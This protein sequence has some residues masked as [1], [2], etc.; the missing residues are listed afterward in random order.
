M[1]W[2]DVSRAP[3]PSYGHIYDH[4]AVDFEYANGAHVLSMCRQ[5]D[6]TANHVGERFIG[7]QGTTDGNSKITGPRAY[8][9][10]NSNESERKNPYVEEHVDLLASIRAGKPLNEGHQVAESTLTAIMGREAAYTGQAIVWDDML[11][12]SLDLTPTSSGSV[13]CS[14]HRWRSRG[15]R[16]SPAPGR[17]E[18]RD[19]RPEP[20]DFTWRRGFLRRLP[21]PVQPSRHI[22]A[23]R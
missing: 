4:F 12:A 16:R 2:A 21:S 11:N 15:V 22:R 18:S 14:F 8:T 6:G 1:G 20:C 17:T 23:T 13:Q 5:I 19:Q 10:T 9:L 7:T 3:S